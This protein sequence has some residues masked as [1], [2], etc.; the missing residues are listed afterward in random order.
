MSVQ[1][2]YYTSW[3]DT[4]P[5]GE[6]GFHV[7][8]VSP[9]I[10]PDD[11]R[12]LTELIA[13][14]IP[15]RLDPRQIAT[16]PVA[17]R[18]TYL[19]PDKAVLLCSQSTGKDEQ[20]RT[21]NFFAHAIMLDPEPFTHTPPVFFWGSSFWRAS[22]STPGDAIPVLSSFEVEPSLNLDQV[23]RFIADA[24]RRDWLYRL[25]C[26]VIHCN[27]TQRRIVIVDT[28]EHV[29]LWVAAV[30]LM[31]P[32]LYRPLLSFATYHNDPYQAGYLITGTRSDVDFH[33]T[34]P[35]FL[36]FFTLDTE[37]GRVSDIADSAYARFAA[38]CAR[39]DLYSER[40]LGLLSMC[41]RLFPPDGAIGDQLDDAAAYYA[42]VLTKSG[43]LDPAARRAMTIAITTLDQVS[44]PTDERLEDLQTAHMLLIST[45]S[46]TPEPELIQ[47]YARVVAMMRAADPDGAPAHLPHDLLLV[48]KLIVTGK[49]REG[50][51]ISEIVQRAYGEAAVIAGINSPEYLHELTRL[52]ESAPLPAMLGVWWFA[53]KSVR[54][55]PDSVPSL[56]AMLKRA[57]SAS[58]GAQDIE[59][60]A[61]STRS[62]GLSWLTA[63]A[64]D[65]S[66]SPDALQAYYYALVSHMPPRERASYRALMPHAEELPEYE[67]I[68]DLSG[69]HMDGNLEALS[70][71]AEYASEDSN[72]AIWISTGMNHLWGASAQRDQPMIAKYA[73]M[74]PAIISQLHERSIGTLLRTAFSG[75]TLTRPDEADLAFCQQYWQDPRLNFAEHTLLIGVLAMDSGR[76]DHQSA[77]TLRE[78]FSQ[79]SVEQYATE[80][81]D[82]I[83]RFFEQ[84]VSRE[85]HAEMVVATY[86]MQYNDVFWQSYGSAL[87]T[88]M[89]DPQ[90][91][92]KTISLLGFWFDSSLSELGSYPYVVQLFFM[93]LPQLFETAQKERGYRDAARDLDRYASEQ[94][95][96]PLVKGMITPERKSI[97]GRL[98]F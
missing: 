28:P 75:L 37:T 27:T 63:L 24:Q 67:I 45:L 79:L 84:D 74:R 3:V 69:S 73:L 17:L 46:E 4:S 35:D 12:L 90:M 5:G 47:D 77:T 9:G 48:T 2:F 91:A 6:A 26:A 34:P 33:L 10:T 98:G 8:G 89:I 15:P 22:D 92:Q 59:T 7:R 64:P 58:G 66:I 20:G 62:D 21:G 94:R 14:A 70:G 95:W 55:A 1:Q 18:Y 82:F 85:S 44:A 52:S 49:T 43:P 30:S 76:L 72:G 86:N 71:W 40:M 80:A 36:S 38:D 53:G 16:H 51:E 88:L 65:T 31:L 93:G 50:T 23:W 96:Y 87:L 11:K 13:Y 60:L 25:L 56:T 54:A 29:A 39:P 57:P 41:D 78:R 81:R 19:S 83:N 42:R 61:D 32:S 68:R 97:L